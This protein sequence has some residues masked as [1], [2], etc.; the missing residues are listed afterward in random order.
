M[1]SIHKTLTGRIA[2][3]EEGGSGLSAPAGA[4][5]I[6]MDS[7]EVGSPEAAALRAAG[8]QVLTFEQCV[9]VMA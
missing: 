5:P 4:L 1:S 3:L 7:E 2:R 9:E 8:Y 6:V